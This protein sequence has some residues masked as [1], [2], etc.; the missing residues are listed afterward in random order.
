MNATQ[1]QAESS[2]TTRIPFDSLV[3]RAVVHELQEHLI[4]GQIQDVRQPTSTDITLGIR[5]HNRNY[6]LV[7]SAEAQYARIHL[8]R[9]RR[10]NPEMPPTFCMALRKHIENRRIAAI[11]QRDFDRVVELD[12]IG[13]GDDEESVTVTLVAELMG[14]HSNLVLVNSYGTILEAAKRISKRINRVRE[15]L[16]GL[17]YQPPPE[18][19]DRVDPFSVDAVEKLVRELDSL[20]HSGDQGL[21]AAVQQIYAGMS[22]FLAREIASRLAAS[23]APDRSTA[24]RAVWSE[25]FGRAGNGDY[26]PVLIRG[27]SEQPLG[28]YPFPVL[29]LAACDQEAVDEIDFALDESFTA[30]IGHAGLDAAQAE[31]RGQIER[32]IKRLER[33]RAAATRAL[34]EAG[35]AEEYKKTGDLLLANLWRIRP[36]DETVV[37]QDYYHPELPELTIA[38]NP[39][40]SAHE[41][42]DNLFQR[43]RKAR[44]GQEKE[45][46]R[47]AGA[48]R[49]LKTLTSA[50]EELP[51][52]AAVEAIRTLRKEL[53]AGRLL[54]PGSDNEAS[55]GK[56][57]SEFQGHKIRRYYTTDG[58]EILVG[59][60]ATANDFLTTRVAASNDLWLHV[61]AAAS[62]HVVIRT[63]GRPDA[64][65]RHVI[66]RAA[67]LCAR[68]S[69]HKHSVLVSVDYTLKK[70]VRKPRGAAPG[71]ADYEKEITIDVNPL[72]DSA[73]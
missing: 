55:D 65:P 33:Q 21:V 71:G 46:E 45:R 42:A 19:P 14:K 16:P 40:L 58:F 30:I 4:G 2:S 62:A 67:V 44:D 73:E 31:L 20:Q 56:R 1:K 7:L 13:R 27:K 60:S 17:T 52:L 15:T 10:P 57:E 43:Y 26:E 36:G 41:N 32:E 5:N 3:L 64:V 69:V 24:L 47:I 22:P 66:E 53:I 8:S 23:A 25:L 37:V 18:Q 68:H 11:T 38:L 50:L 35:R 49:E 51:R 48:E 12:V 70:Y 29:H 9:T 61:R 6:L 34:Q 59:E 72:A 63:H 28:A 54:R 39:R